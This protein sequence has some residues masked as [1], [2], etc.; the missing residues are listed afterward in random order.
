MRGTL[1]GRVSGWAPAPCDPKA[2]IAWLLHPHYGLALTYPAR[3]KVTQ[4][5]P[6]ISMTLDKLVNAS[7]LQP[8]T[9]KWK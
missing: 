1:Q 8:S 3:G 5:L 2:N 9:L 6:P 7:I 4:P